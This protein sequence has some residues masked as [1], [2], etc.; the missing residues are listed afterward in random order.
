MYR[1]DDVLFSTDWALVVVRKRRRRQA[2]VVE[3]VAGRE[4]MRLA[5]AGAACAARGAVLDI[6]R[7]DTLE[8][9]DTLVAC[10]CRAAIGVVAAASGTTISRS[11]STSTRPL[12]GRASWRSIRRASWL[13]MRALFAER[14]SSFAGSS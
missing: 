6:R 11:T 2:S 13:R 1:V 14:T 10:Q 7:T 4:S 5:G 3:S 8:A 12:G 9:R